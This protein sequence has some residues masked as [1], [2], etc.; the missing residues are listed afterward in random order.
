MLERII[1]GIKL[2]CT[3]ILIFAWAWVT[4]V[5]LMYL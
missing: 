4:L 3:A 5:G 2:V 1:D